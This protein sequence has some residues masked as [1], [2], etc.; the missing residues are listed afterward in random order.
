M[1]THNL[2][3]RQHFCNKV[4]PGT[5]NCP[6]ARWKLKGTEIPDIKAIKN[7]MSAKLIQYMK[8]SLSAKELN[9]QIY[10]RAGSSNFL[11]QRWMWSGYNRETNKALNFK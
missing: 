11:P 8:S 2:M 9:N 7:K 1:K 10:G 3:E 4:I 5:K 6:K